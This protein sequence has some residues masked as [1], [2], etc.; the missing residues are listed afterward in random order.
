MIQPI[1]KETI[2]NNWTGLIKYKLS[3]FCNLFEFYNPVVIDW[4]SDAPTV[5][6]LCRMLPYDNEKRKVIEKNI[7]N[8]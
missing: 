7:M 6:K 2:E 1:Y 5:L 4:R 3:W 8:F